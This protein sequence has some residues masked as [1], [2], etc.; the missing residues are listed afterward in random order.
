MSVLGFLGGLSAILRAVLSP[1]RAVL[2]VCVTV[3]I[4]IA[5][6]LGQVALHS[7]HGRS[8]AHTSS[9]ISSETGASPIQLAACI[10][11]RWA[12]ST[13]R[14]HASGRDVAARCHV[15]QGNPFRGPNTLKQNPAS[16][17]PLVKQ[18]TPRRRDPQDDKT[19]L[20]DNRSC[21]G[22]PTF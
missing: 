19:M 6:L 10:A 1:R 2:H 22:W 3:T 15:V 7:T 4:L 21:G 8:A 17:I 9:M 11:T 13:G 16:S 12:A 18:C 20:L 5:E 14:L